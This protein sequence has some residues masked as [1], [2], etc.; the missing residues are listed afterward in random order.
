MTISNPSFADAKA[1]LRRYRTSAVVVTTLSLLGCENTSHKVLPSLSSCYTFQM[2]EGELLPR[3][4]ERRE[5]GKGD[6]ADELLQD[7]R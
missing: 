3:T 1:I 2:M 7:R 5:K 6:W 4:H